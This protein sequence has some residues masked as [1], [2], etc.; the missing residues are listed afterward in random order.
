MEMPEPLV[1]VAQN[2][3]LPSSLLLP[4]KTRT[5]A[6]AYGHTQALIITA[7]PTS[8]QNQTRTESDQMV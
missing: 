5:S 7:E 6:Q 3:L 2:N 1:P 4:P 8:G